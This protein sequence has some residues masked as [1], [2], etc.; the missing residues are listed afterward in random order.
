MQRLRRP[1]E[2]PRGAVQDDCVNAGNTVCLK[3]LGVSALLGVLST[4]YAGSPS[5]TIKVPEG[6]TARVYARDLAGAREL[7]IAADGTLRLR[8]NAATFEITPPRDDSP[9]LVLRV[10]T[11]L[12]NAE[13]TPAA[14]LAAPLNFATMTI[15]LPISMETL[16]LARELDQL[17]ATDV[18]LSPD[19][20]LYVADARAGV[21]Y[22]VVRRTAL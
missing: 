21:V 16:A 10:A 7:R 17:T 9:M 18:A 20:T 1:N 14:A 22:K 12:D 5:R 8:C 4:A 6:F 2:R 11:E 3:R 19:G 13:A 15:P